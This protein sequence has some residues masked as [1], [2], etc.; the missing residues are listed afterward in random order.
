MA[1]HAPSSKIRQAG[2]NLLPNVDAVHDI[3][4]CRR[5]WEAANQL[6]GLRFNALTLYGC[7]G[8]EVKLATAKHRGKWPFRKGLM[9]LIVLV[10]LGGRA[11]LRRAF[12]G[13][14]A[15]GGLVGLRE[16]LGDQRPGVALGGGADR[17]IGQA[18][19]DE[20]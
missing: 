7:G 1:M 4:P 9:A 18:Q 11:S 2:L 5:F 17:A 10:A 19:R 6:D 8:H 20:E 3:V 15:E 16:G 12:L 13:G 14:A